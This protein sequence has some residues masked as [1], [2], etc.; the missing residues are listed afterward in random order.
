MVEKLGLK[1]ATL[2]LVVVLSAGAYAFF[3]MDFIPECKPE[4]VQQSLIDCQPHQCAFSIV[5]D[6]EQREVIMEIDENCNFQ[7][8]GKDF[9]QMTK[10]SFNDDDYK[11]DIHSKI[12][13][14][15][16]DVGEDMFEKKY[17][18]N[19]ERIV[20][21]A[22]LIGAIEDQSANNTKSDVMTCEIYS[23]EIFQECGEDFSQDMLNMCEVTSTL[24]RSCEFTSPSTGQPARI[25]ISDGSAVNDDYD[26]CFRYEA[27]EGGSIGCYNLTDDENEKIAE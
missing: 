13:Y 1:L 24:N 18:Y 25:S 23:P 9:T 17:E 11:D 27:S 7:S 4:E 19:G 16:T 5:V 26:P 8:L 10:C 14:D 6:D 22:F 3:Y 2:F 21:E 12:L 20:G 15:L